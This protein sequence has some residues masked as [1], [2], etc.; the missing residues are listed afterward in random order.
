MTNKRKIQRFKRMQVKNSKKKMYAEI[1]KILKDNNKYL[2]FNPTTATCFF[3]SK[4][5][6]LRLKAFANALSCIHES[7]NEYKERVEKELGEGS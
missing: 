3:V 7:F 5:T 2:F 1:R 4:P 6:L